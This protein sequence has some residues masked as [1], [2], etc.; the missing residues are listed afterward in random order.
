MKNL[1]LFFALCVLCMLSA[2]TE[3]QAQI[4]NPKEYANNGV[5]FKHPQ[6]WKVTEDKR[7]SDLRYIFVETPGDALIIFQ[8]YGIANDMEL[9]G[10]ANAF[11]GGAEEETPIGRFSPSTFDEPVDGRLKENLSIS[12]LGQNIPHTREY[13][14][15]NYGNEVCFLVFQVA[16]EDLTKTRKGFDL[17]VESF[18]Y[19]SSNQ[20][21]DDNSE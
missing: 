7:T 8:F 9:L 5:S 15:Y 19:E 17:I 2:C 13:L 20:S 14:K 21:G 12:V 11:S 4:S 16:D 6:N 10:Y 3:P 1:N 18:K